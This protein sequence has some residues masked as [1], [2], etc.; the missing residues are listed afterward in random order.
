MRVWLQYL[1]ANHPDY[2]RNKRDGLLEIS[3][4]ALSALESQ[5]ELAEVLEDVNDDDDGDDD[6]NND[7][8]GVES[9]RPADEGVVQPAMESGMSS[10][11]VYTF[12]K[13]PLLYLKAKD[14][15]KISQDGS[16]RIIED[17]QKRIP[18]YGAS[19][20]STFPYLYPKGERSPLDFSDYKMARQLLKRQTLFAYKLDHDRYKWEYAMDDIHMM[21]SYARLVERTVNAKT[22]WFLQQSPD[23][24]HLP[25]DQVLESFKAGFESQDGIVDSKM[26]GLSSLMTQLP[27]SRESWFAQRM[28]IEAIGRDRNDCNVFMTLN[29]SPRE[30]YDTR[31]LLHRLEHGDQV[32]FDPDYYEYDTERF[33]ELMN[34]HAAHMSVYLSRKTKLF[35]NAFLCD[36]CGI[37]KREAS[38]DWTKDDRDATGYYW[39]EVEFTSTRGVQ[40]WHCLVKLP[41]VLDTSIIG[42]LIQN[43][44]VLRQEIKCVNVKEDRLEDAWTAV[45]MG[46]LADRYAKMFTDSIST[47]SFYTEDMDLDSHDE[48]KVISIEKQ[49]NE[50]V[51]NYRDKNVNM[52][53]HPCMRRWCDVEF[54]DKHAEMAKVAAVSCIHNCIP[55]ICG[56]RVKDGAGCRFD[57]PKKR[58]NHTV[59]GMM[60]VNSTQ[61]EA[62]MLLRRTCDRVPNLNDYFLLYWRGNH[63]VTVLIDASHKMRYATKYAAKSGQYSELINEVLEYVN[64]RNVKDMPPNM[65]TVL[66]QLLL[67]DVSHRS[68]MTKQQLAYYVMDLAVVRK[69]FSDVHV[70]S[71]YRR[72]NVNVSTTDGN[73]IVYSDRTEYSAY[74]ERCREDTKIENGKKIKEEQRLTKDKLASM[75]FREFA[76]TVEHNWIQHDNAA[77]ELGEASSRKFKT[78]IVNDGHWVMKA[79][80]K[81]RHIRFSTVLYTDPAHRYEPVELDDTTTQTSFFSLPVNKRRQLYRAYME[82]VCYVPWTNDPETLLDDEQRAVLNNDKQGADVE[83]RYNLRR[84]EMFWQVY[85][86]KYDNGEVAPAGSQWQRDNQYS[87]SMY[88]TTKHNTDVHVQRLEHD[89]TLSARYEADDEVKESGID[90]HVD[91]QDAVDRCSYPSALNFLPPDTFREVVDQQPPDVSEVN[92]AFPMQGDYQQ[93]EETV[94]IDRCKLFLAQ[95]PASTV[96]YDN[97]TDVQKWAYQLGIDPNQQIVYICGKAGSGKTQV[98]LKICEHFSGRV[99]AA[100]V[101][102]KA[103]SLFGAPTVHGMFKWTCYDKTTYGDAPTASARKLTELRTFYEH[104]DVFV[105]DEVNAMS[106]AMLAQMDET[107]TNIFNPKL[108][109]T[110]GVLPPFGS[111]KIILC[112][113]G[114]QLSPVVGEPI[115]GA[116]TSSADKSEKVRSARVANGRRCIS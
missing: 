58:L 43:G 45:E 73:T 7:D 60:Q 14:F 61:M 66:S 21:W 41:H 103:A 101:T 2:I 112:G 97:F 75:N 113:D 76:E 64:Q 10:S 47:S 71:F 46:L 93:L 53:T 24:Q 90:L 109:R 52:S 59:P 26:A 88:L 77:K 63:D 16:I 116:G 68:F 51:S 114:A 48:S 23:T 15:M 87:Y 13:Y 32:P 105:I 17:R 78:R 38:G 95:P 98:A 96:P 83:F 110:R 40:H 108:K 18:I 65:Q 106:A 92:V 37:S 39:T 62:R 69:S 85:M 6:N 4:S 1:F 3:E 104:I 34:R 107:M 74:A 72:S 100:A 35:L 49:R 28:G 79:R 12:D 27:H 9:N 29:S 80:R 25:I 86:K 20:T 31:L 54:R 99:Q 33:T 44:R 102:G 30:T 22:I 89:G 70:V 57:F 67:V 91:L 56:G 36:I 42:R 111:K 81:R 94:R 50:F 5:S 115:Y 8:D 19:A 84:L 11:D 55:S 82:L